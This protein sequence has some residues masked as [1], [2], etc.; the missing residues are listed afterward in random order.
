MPHAHRRYAI[1]FVG[2]FFLSGIVLT[3][4]LLRYQYQNVHR[5]MALRYQDRELCTMRAPDPRLIYTYVPN[6]C[7]ANTKGY[8]DA[9]YAYEKS[10]AIYRLVI[11]GDSVA[12]GLSRTEKFG[13][14]LEQR[15]NT[16]LSPHM[17]L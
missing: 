3:E 9:E 14:I 10:P 16:N 5:K 17:D 13:K 2:F 1:A 6:R 7:G 12:S 4:V 11:I 8:I 15:L